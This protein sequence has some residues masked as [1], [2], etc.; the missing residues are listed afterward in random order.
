MQRN[1]ILRSKRKAFI[2]TVSL[3]L[4]LI[5]CAIS[6]VGCDKTEKD[7]KDGIKIVCSVFPIYDWTRKI[8]GDTERVSVELLVA[9]GADLHSYQAS[10]SDI[11]T[12]RECDLLICVGGE[13]DGWIEAALE[14]SGADTRVLRL[15]PLLEEKGLAHH[16]AEGS[17]D[18]GDLN[19]HALD[20]H[21][22]LSP[23]LAPMLCEAIEKQI[24][25][26]DSG[27]NSY[28]E[29][30]EQYKEK[31]FA[32]DQAYE[33]TIENSARKPLIFADRFPFR[34]LTEDYSIEYRAA[35]S[36][37]S[38]DSEASFENIR[39]LAIF[40]DENSLGYLLTL[41]GSSDSIADAVISATK[42][43]TATILRLNSMQSV[44]ERDI[45]KGAD[46]I[47]IMKNNLSLI[48]LALG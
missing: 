16:A 33:A 24:S 18:H 10:V 17:H 42:S 20:E 30:L 37:C 4:C 15:L 27:E 43:K 2:R 5:I 46:Y 6:A 11:I 45:E 22:W 1:N 28:S 34:Y 32:L 21:V 8:V 48:E 3:L 23:K 36:S 9:N 40:F 14:S 7:K 12:L 41:E 19:E 47:E 44:T 35:F 13:S 39:D 26:L 31:L 38:S 29:N 25:E